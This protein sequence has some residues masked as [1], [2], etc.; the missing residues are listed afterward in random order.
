LGVNQA[1]LRLMALSAV[2]FFSLVACGPAP[3]A[4]APQ[5]AAAP[6]SLNQGLRFIAAEPGEGDVIAARVGGTVITVS[7]V[8][9]EAVA[10]ELIEDSAELP[11]GDPVFQEALS[12]LIDQRLLA[13]EAARRGLDQDP[14]ARRRLAAAE[15]R[16]LSNVLVENAIAQ[17]V[18][19]EAV[20]RVYDE[21]AQLAP[22]ST[23]VRARH[24]LVESREEA[25]EAIR[26]LADG[27]SFSDLAMRISRD[28]AT[29]LIGGDL[30]YFTRAGMIPVFAE[31]AFATEEGAVSAPFETEFGWHVLTVVDRRTQP[32]ASL[33]T[34]RPNIVRFLTLQEIDALLTDLRT[35]YPVVITAGDAPLD[36]RTSEPEAPDEADA[37]APGR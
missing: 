11:A 20:E 3:V 23:E 4:D 31:V 1:P 9:R 12:E 24:I 17:A 7:E 13:L 34:M 8:R 36:L 6:D 19:D 27:V 22:R 10:R 35:N 30:G 16:I 26:I 29:R 37:D 33:E 2:L 18:T 32:R 28:P 25:A 5:P 14:E 15:E 21:Q